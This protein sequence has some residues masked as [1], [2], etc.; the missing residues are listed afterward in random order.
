[1]GK[2][3]LGRRGRLFQDS[4]GQDFNPAQ[5]TIV[6]I[7]VAKTQPKAAIFDYF[8]TPLC[9]SFFFTPDHR[10]VEKIRN[11][12]DEI[13]NKAG[14]RFTVFG[15]E[16]TGHYQEPIVAGLRERNC[17]V[18]PINAITTHEER[19]A[20]LDYSKTDDLDLYAIASAVAGGKVT[21]GKPPQGCQ[22][23]LRFLTRT[24]RSH[25]LERAKA[26]TDLHTLLD[27]FWPALQGIPEVA[28]GKPKLSPI[29]DLKSDQA[30]AFLRHVKTPA[31]ALELGAEG[32]AKLSRDKG[33]RLGQRRIGLILQ[34]AELAAKTD[35]PLLALYIEQ[36][37][38]LL[39]KIGS[40]GERIGRLESQSEE[41]LA[42]TPGVLLLS[43]PGIGQVTAAEFMAEAGLAIHGYPSASAVI[44]L[45]GTN[46]VPDNSGK[47]CGRMRISKQG[48]PHLRE[49]VY[50]IG[51]NLSE[52]H[53]NP[54]FNAF[55]ERLVG[56]TTNQKRIAVGNKFIRVAYA[57]LT[58]GEIFSPKTWL[59]PPLAVDP[60]RKL[61]PKNRAKAKATLARLLRKE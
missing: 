1:M 35:A 28:D 7:D 2:G 29:F 34:A 33:L 51:K 18:M 49:L 43:A 8:G 42:D 9:E 10:G 21:L 5:L 36:L 22:A 41:I 47:H 40:L 23:Q 19:K 59:G 56:L 26:Y 6:A 4:F 12:A 11:M 44:K 52:L 46:P 37:D 32:L 13:A 53:P 57:M 14:K 25:V 24:R 48:S 27:H 50:T 60:L 45:A 30:L 20:L 54:Y 3:K 58:R 16:N 39:N 15:I 17:L 55:R 61:E 31:Q 38:N